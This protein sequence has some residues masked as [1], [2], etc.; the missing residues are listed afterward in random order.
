MT[1]EEFSKG[2]TLLRY[3]YPYYFKDMD[4]T[5]KR[6]FLEAWYPFFGT[7]KPER[8]LSAIQSLIVKS[9]F[10]PSIHD[11]KAEIAYLSNPFLQ[12]NPEAEWASVIAAIRDYGYYREPEAMQSLGRPTREVV[13]TLGWHRICMTT[14]D[15]VT[16]L[17]KEFCYMLKSKK[18]EYQRLGIT[19]D[20]QPD[21]F[22]QEV[23]AR[24]KRLA[25]A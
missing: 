18:D 11:L 7:E 5:E 16:G 4:K 3:A 24:V 21:V 9:K 2:V 8:L 19:G 17:K 13:R 20:Y 14:N 25:G 23:S 10:M 1:K 6:E 12:A 22:L 15:C